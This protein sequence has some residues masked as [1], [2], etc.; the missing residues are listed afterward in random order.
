MPVADAALQMPWWARIQRLPAAL[1]RHWRSVGLVWFLLAA[2]ASVGYH[3]PDEHYQI[4]EFCNYKLGFSGSADLAWEYSVQ[5]RPGM[6]PAIA[7]CLA[8]VLLYTGLYDPFL[9]ALLLRVGM[10]VLWW[11]ICCWGVARMPTGLSEGAQKWVAPA[12]LAL[13][14]MPYVCVRYSAENFSAALFFTAV[15]V[16][17]LKH[18][19]R[20][21]APAA[22][23]AAGFLI[24]VALSARPQMVLA[25]VGLGA[26]LLLNRWRLKSFAWMAAGAVLATGVCAVADGWL[27]GAWVFPPYRYFHENIVKGVAASFGTEP[28]WWYGKAFLAY[29]V[30]PLSI[31]ML[32]LAARGVVAKPLGL[33]AL[34]TLAFV[35]GHSLVGHKEMRFLFPM[36]LPFIVLMCA[37]ADAMHAKWRGKK[38]ARGVGR[39]AIAFNAVLLIFRSFAP[40]NDAALA[41]RVVY[42]LVPFW[43]NT[44]VCIGTDA[45]RQHGIPARFYQRPGLLVG[46]VQTPA[47]VDSFLQ[48]NGRTQALLITG[49]KLPRQALPGYGFEEDYCYFP[50]WLL[51]LNVGGWVERANVWTVYTVRR[52]K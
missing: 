40:A 39:V 21:A 15:A 3:H 52:R 24:G 34:I 49:Q 19:A 43:G 41:Q 31:L 11:W 14:W 42:S 26:W 37:G 48:H 29:A 51:R 5:C 36:S 27:Y 45:Y 6:Q 16:L 13:W 46:T 4:L 33:M 8:T 25:A 1:L 28:W 10:A 22:T 7:Y 38:W 2:Y 12:L 9:L 30:P 32:V 18:D 47:G 35:I 44:V 50:R 20:A 17:R 23:L